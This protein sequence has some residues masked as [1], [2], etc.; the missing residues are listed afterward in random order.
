MT[1]SPPLPA[2]CHDFGYAPCPVWAQLAAQEPWHEVTAVTTDQ[3]DRVYVFNRG[4]HPVMA[5][6][7][8]GEFITAWGTQ[9]FRRPHGIVAG[10]D[11]SLY[12][13]DD[14]GHSVRRYSTEGKL[15]ATI[16]P[17]GTPSDTGSTSIDYRTIQR[18]AGPYHYPTNLAVAANGDLYVSDGYG[19]ARVHRF[20]ADGALR[21]S[22]GRPGNGPGEFHVPHGIAVDRA[23]RVVVAD[24]ENSRLQWF[25]PSGEFLEEW[26]DVVRPCQ[27]F[28]GMDERVFVAELGYRAGM[29]PGTAAPHP[30]ASGGRLSIFDRAGELLARWGGGDEPKAPG[31]FFAPH[32]VWVDRQGA[33]YVS[34]VVMSAGGNRGLVAP[35]CHTLQKFVP[36]RPRTAARPT[37]A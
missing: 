6:S 20:A 31:D 14:L 23:G 19:N 27:V 35:D 29:W 8:A 26:I 22:W 24:R 4:E 1:A 34:E 37:G 5:Y 32:D 11:D 2:S 15:L 30:R 3:H 12:C 9:Q 13:V 33:I 18:A 21:Q 28:V 17:A 16:G 7:A 36:T 10:A 25:T